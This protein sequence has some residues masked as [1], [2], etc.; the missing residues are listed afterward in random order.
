MPLSA[1]GTCERP[2]TSEPEIVTAASNFSLPAPGRYRARHH[3]DS[4]DEP[5]LGVNMVPSVDERPSTSEPEI[6]TA[7]SNFSLPAPGRYRARHH[8]DS[9][10]E[11]V[12]GVNMVPSVD[13]RPST[14]EPEIVTAASNFSLPA[15]GRYRAPRPLEPSAEWTRAD[16]PQKHNK[17]TPLDGGDRGGLTVPEGHAAP[18][19]P[20]AG[21]SL[22]IL[23]CRGVQVGDDNQQ[24]NSY[25]YRVMEP[26]VDF[27]DVL[28]RPPVRDAL[29]RLISDPEN[30]ELQANAEK[31]LCAGS[32]KRVSEPEILKLGP[33]GRA[34]LDSGVG[35]DIRAMQGF[36]MLRRCEGVQVGNDCTQL[37]DFTY[38]CRR[39]TV[40]AHSLL[41]AF[42]KVASS[43]VE[44]LVNPSETVSAESLNTSVKAALAS[45]DVL[46]AI[47]DRSTKVG[48]RTNVVR[49]CDGVSIGNRSLTDEFKS[50]S[51]ELG[52]SANLPSSVLNESERLLREHKL[53]QAKAVRSQA[54][55]PVTA[56]TPRRMW[57]T[58]GSSRNCL[59][60]SQTASPRPD[61]P[62][63]GRGIGGM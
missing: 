32:W 46:T 38:V 27:S 62:S 44:A 12:L 30:E 3:W 10:D 19:P 9:D 33:L 52:K 51:V 21:P 48:P 15:P 17:W 11:P 31:A 24:F 39:S 23:G 47:P 40:S 4:D 41:K 61:P 34:S 43:L 50:I 5:V 18:S 13:E 25:T 26:S 8:W 1:H 59:P 49:D 55:L 57:G 37:N 60:E 42:P 56:V 6:V 22:L 28:R 29:R 14:S 54:T 36:V 2:S 7:A 63:A 35:R 45:R 20:V 58:P 16:P 53:A